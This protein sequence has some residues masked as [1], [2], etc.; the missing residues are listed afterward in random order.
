MGQLCCTSTKIILRVAPW[1][2]GCSGV[3]EYLPHIHE[4]L[5]SVEQPRGAVNS[6]KED[7]SWAGTGSRCQL[8][9]KHLVIV[10]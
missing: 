6:I 10:G 5:G 4:A 1:G 3:E 8:D 9:Q 2:L 7:R